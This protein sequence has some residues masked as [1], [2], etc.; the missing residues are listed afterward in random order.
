VRGAVILLAAAA[1]ALAVSAGAASATP[2]PIVLGG[3]VPLSGPAVL[4]ASVARG[5]EAYFRYV[6]ARGGVDGRPI[7]YVYRDDQYLVPQTVQMTKELVEQDKVLALFNSVGTPNGIAVR[8][9]LK[10]AGVPQLLQGS[11]TSALSLGFL[12]SFAGEGRVYGRHIAATS[13]A[14]CAPGSAPGRG[15]SSRPCPTR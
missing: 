14:G 9:Y 4:L 7:R 3:T 6:N 5:A 12:P 13:S 11:G 2:A 8:D 10:A 15:R 1:A